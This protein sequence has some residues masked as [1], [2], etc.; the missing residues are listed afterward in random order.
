MTV[1]DAIDV[2]LKA[3]DVRMRKIFFPTK[4]WIANYIRPIFPDV[5][6]RKLYAMAKL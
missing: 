1:E 3:I 2:I 5:I 4:A 6:D